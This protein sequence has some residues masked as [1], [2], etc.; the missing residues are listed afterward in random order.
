MNLNFPLHQHIIG[1]SISESTEMEKLGYHTT[2]LKDAL[3]EFARFMLS[4]GATLAYGGD[5][6]AGGFTETLFELVNTYKG[7]G[8]AARIQSYL[9]W[10]IHLKLSISDRARIQQA[11]KIRALPAPEIPGLDATTF[12]PPIDAPSTYVWCK[13]LTQMRAKMAKAN[14][15]Q[16]LMGG[17][18]SGYKGKYPGLVEEAYEYMKAEKPVFLIGA[19]GGCASRMAEA[20]QGGMIPELTEA[21]QIQNPQYKEVLPYYNERVTSDEE[22]IDYER[23]MEFFNTK[24]IK[25]LNNYLTEAENIRLFSTPHL[26]EIIALVLKG[27]QAIPIPQSSSHG[28]K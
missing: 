11:A 1:I 12:L 13:S 2:H 21:F 27:L 19:F 26:P 18:L 15:A 7:A 4:A 5:L 3:I 28:N 24:G 16:I 10:P 8:S 22:R 9:A 25:G 23:L 17:R 6:R 20:L 14:H